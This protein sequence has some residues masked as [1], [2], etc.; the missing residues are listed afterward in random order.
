MSCFVT[1][2]SERSIQW[3]SWLLDE[4]NKNNEIIYK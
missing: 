3:E 4:N 1:G 2:L